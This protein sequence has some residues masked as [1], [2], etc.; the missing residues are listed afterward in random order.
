MNTFSART[1]TLSLALAAFML[2]AITTLP[3]GA[4]AES[5]EYGAS[6]A[7]FTVD[8]PNDWI[9]KSNKN[10]VALT[11]KDK[12]S[13]LGLLAY[14]ANGMTIDAFVADALQNIG[15]KNA[16]KQRD[17]SFLIT[18]GKNTMDMTVLI[19][20]KDKHFVIVITAGPD[21]KGMQAIANSLELKKIPEKSNE[22]AKEAPQK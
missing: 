2:F 1:L 18:D 21:K 13:T 17:G 16:K 15:L 7:I 6:D 5:T 10:G 9:A 11:S 12:E 19:T 22:T 3:V 20:Q 4:R 8:V 14:P